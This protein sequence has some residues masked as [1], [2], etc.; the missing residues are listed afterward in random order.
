VFDALPLV[1]GA[2]LLLASSRCQRQ[3]APFM[4]HTRTQ[5]NPLH[6]HQRTIIAHHLIL[7]LYG[8]W[9]PNDIRGSG[10]DVVHSEDLA[11]LGPIHHGRKP[12]HLQPTREELRAFHKQ[13][14][15]VLYHPVFW[16]DSAKR[17]ALTET[18]RDV[19]RRNQYTVYACAICR[20]HVHLVIRRHR[21]DALTMWHTLAE[22][23]IERLRRGDF[24]DVAPVNNIAHHQVLASRPY[25]VFLF[26]PQ[27]TWTRISY[28]EENPEKEGL[29][30]QTYD[31]VTAYNNWRG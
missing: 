9:P 28:T 31:F 3:G 11:A 8:H 2:L 10:S 25:K 15:Q 17:Q 27:E 21:D 5:I 12:E 26:T 29:A 19:V 23:M 1:V 22:A 18:F 7:T 13:V 24:F 6:T 14:K 20:N 4:S 30:R 16:L